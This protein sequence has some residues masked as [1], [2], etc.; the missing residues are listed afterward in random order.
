MKRCPNCL[1]AYDE[2][3]N[4][5]EA[6]GAALTADPFETIPAQLS[7]AESSS[8][9]S[10]EGWYLAAIGVLAGVL[11]CVTVYFGYLAPTSQENLNQTNSVAD[12]FQTQQR[13]PPQQ[14]ATPR[15]PEETRVA[16]D[17]TSVESEDE[18]A[19][20]DPTPESSPETASATKRFNDGPISTGT[21]RIETLEAIV[22]FTDGTTIKVEAAWENDQGVWYR[23]GG[24]VSFVERERVKSITESV[25]R[26][27]QESVET[28]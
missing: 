2:G 17:E 24:L 8:S 23:R 16:D 1:S 20:A 28:P 26:A 10:R 5:C 14:T 12:R 15:R 3:Q 11:M 4:F 6:D 21:K 13:F 22:Q 19:T 7:P 25:A 9:S 18:E 27:T